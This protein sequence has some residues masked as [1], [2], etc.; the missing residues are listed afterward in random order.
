MIS[1][2]LLRTADSEAYGLH[3]NS[4]LASMHFLAVAWTIQ[5]LFDTLETVLMISLL[6][7]APAANLTVQD[8]NKLTNTSL[9][10]V[11]FELHC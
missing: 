2:D 9:R 1:C 11:S 5:A 7:L 10:L 8:F 3:V 6:T 4:R